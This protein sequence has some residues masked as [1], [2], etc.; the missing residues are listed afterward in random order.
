MRHVVQRRVEPQVHLPQRSRGLFL[1]PH[2]Y[3]KASNL[4]LTYKIYDDYRLHP[5]K[6]CA[7]LNEMYYNAARNK[8]FAD[9][10]SPV[11]N[12]YADKV[13]ELYSK[14][15]LI[16][17]E[18]NMLHEGKWNHMMDQVHI[19]Y[20]YWQQPPYNRLPVVYSAPVASTSTSRRRGNSWR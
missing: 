17:V 3:A 6:A 11:A 4:E 5:V 14:D 8:F 18:Y 7:N 2:F 15:S 13:K 9:Q 1:L 20:T 10:N 12:Q 19:G 16:S